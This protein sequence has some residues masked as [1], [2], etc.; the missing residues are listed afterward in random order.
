MALISIII[1]MDTLPSEK[2][3]IGVTLF[4]Y[5]KTFDANIGSFVLIMKN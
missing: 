2:L 1:T 4:F 5:H 3:V